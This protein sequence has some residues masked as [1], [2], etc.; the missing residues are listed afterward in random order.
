MAFYLW[1]TLYLGFKGR[2]EILINNAFSQVTQVGL[3]CDILCQTINLILTFCCGLKGMLCVGDLDMDGV[4]GTVAF[5]KGQ[6]FFVIVIICI[7]M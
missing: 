2:D 7:D 4:S 6:F 3:T 1:R 5:E